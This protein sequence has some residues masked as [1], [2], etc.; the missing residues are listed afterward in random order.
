[1]TKPILWGVCIP[2]LLMATAARG[3]KVARAE[4]E[5][6]LRWLLPLPKEVRLEQKVL[7]PVQAVRITLRQGAGEVEANGVRQLL[8]LFREKTGEEPNGEGF[9]IL[10]GVC[11]E[12]GRVD[13][14]AVPS[15]RR[16]RN[17]PN[18]EQAY[19]IEPVG[20]NRLVL[21]ALDERGVFYA[22]QTLR[23]LLEGQFHSLKSAIRNPRSAMAI[24]LV[25]VLDWPDLAER[26]EWGGSSTGDIE[27]M[28][29][30]KMNLVEA[31][32]SL[33]VTPEGRGAARADEAGIERGRLHAL[34]YVP[35]ITHLDQIAGT[36]IYQIFPELK[37]KGPSAQHRAFPDEVAPCFSQ[38]KL[39]EIVADWMKDLAAQKGVSDICCWLSEE[40]LQCECENCRQVGQY[41]LEARAL[42]HAWRLARQEYPHLGLRILLTQ[43]SYSTNDKVLA[44]VP[45]EVGVTYYDG[46]RTYNSS[47]DP[48]IYPLL[49]QYAAAGHWLGCYPQLTASWRIVCPWSGPQFIKY[50]M[51]EFVQ[52]KLQ[53]LCGYATPHNRL[54][55]FNIQ[56]AAEWSWNAHGRSEREFAA[57]WATRRGLQ[58]PDKAAEWAVRLGPVGWDVYGSGVPYP[59]FFGHAA[60]VVRKGA[61][62]ALGQGMFRYFPDEAHFDRDL[63]VCEQAM[64]LAQAVGDEELIAETQ[65]IRGYVQM[66]RMIYRIA[67]ESGSDKMRRRSARQALQEKMCAL[68]QAGYETV[69]GLQAWEKAAKAGAGGS[70]F[71]DTVDVTVKTVEDIGKALAPLG[72]KDPWRRFRPARIGGWV[73]EDFAEKEQVRK[74]WEV[75]E[76]VDAPG[77]YGVTFRYTSGWWGLNMSRVAL[78][79]GS[80]EQLTEL[81]V[82]EHPGTAAYENRDNTY[83][84]T[85][86]ERTAGRYFIVADIQGVSSV[87][88][89]E[90]RR[91]CNGEVWLERLEQQEPDFSVPQ[92]GP[93]SPEV[94]SRFVGPQ[95]RGEGLRVGV[96]MGG[97]G[98]ASILEALRAI[99]GVQA[100]PLHRLDKRS[101][102]A[103]Q[104][105]VLP[106]P[107]APESFTAAQAAALRQFVADGGG[108][109]VTHDAVGYRSLPALVPEVCA[110]GV[111]HVRDPAWVVAADHPITQGIAP[112]EK[113]GQ[114]YYDHIE[115]EPGP[116]GT[117]VARAAASGAPVVVV[118][119]I[120]KGRYVACGLALGLSAQDDSD[121]PPQG[122]ERALLEQAVRWAGQIL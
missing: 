17:L 70:R 98:S 84:V 54:Y 13:G 62:P 86:G 71:Q 65:V 76:F 25:H 77:K 107:R 114:T 34:K 33:Q 117:V 16:L 42:V 51:T 89:P 88:K 66:L 109:V 56:A 119:E 47:R 28:A 93:M 90:N 27:W 15:A 19:V 31:H 110:R 11:D 105:L 121:V 49:E 78:C 111:R 120:G 8:A 6:W 36:G 92:V 74:V 43:G 106:Q 46:G 2:A 53:C 20:G 29:S 85:L 94:L 60:E 103:C 72:L 101:I 79:S 57:A 102:R 21:T 63:A 99:A 69:Q 96:V 40:P 55:D 41:A 18:R 26:G 67:G 9:E 97:Y 80:P 48:M 64:G 59:Y 14:V 50:R 37:G 100:A 118:G 7:V 113:H 39:G 45:P 112:G 44:E 61:P 91:G 73:S 23:Q 35:I 95:F 122:A 3:E 83:A 38:P 75:T 58:D 12:A 81:S 30:L 104:V 52:K 10:V 82:D 87:N 1:M 116:Q 24:P 32:V 68:S 22:T 4:R 108:L 115:L 5:R